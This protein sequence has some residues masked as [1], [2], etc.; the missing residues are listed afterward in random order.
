MTMLAED[1][2]APVMPPPRR[3]WWLWGVA[4]AA[5]LAVVGGATGFLVYAHTYNP[6]STLGGVS[7][8]LTP[9]TMKIES[10]AGQEVQYL[11]VGPPG[12]VGT[13][14]FTLWN[15][16]SHGVT[17]LGS[18]GFDPITKLTLTWRRFDQRQDNGV[19]PSRPFPASLGP[20]QA[21]LIQITETQPNCG[22]SV[23]DG[24]T[25]VGTA[26][27]WSAFG[28]HHVFV[29]P[30]NLGSSNM[31]IMSCPPPDVLRSLDAH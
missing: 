26:L 16:G 5:L 19:G 24:R 12:T 10:V 22:T 27:R 9:K 15:N 23:Q 3:R 31:P 6:I 21:V 30:G 13:T 17:L 7:G 4:A 11:L 18:Q 2:A 8:P 28:V 29:D 25:T 1:K 20:G 14:Y